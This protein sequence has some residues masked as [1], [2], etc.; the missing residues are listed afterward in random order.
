MSAAAASAGTR[1]PDSAG[2]GAGRS[3]MAAYGPTL[4]L[5]ATLAVAGFIALMSVVLLVVHPAS[6]PGVLGPQVIL[7]R[8]TAKTG[9]YVAS[10][11]VVLPLALFAG[12]RLADRVV[13]GDNASALA[14]L[15][16]ALAGALAVAIIAVKLSASL[17]W[18]DGLGAML[19]AVAVW[20]ALAGAL[21]AGAARMT[22]NAM[23]SR[24][25]RLGWP[26]FVVAGVLL[27]ATV[28]CLTSL[29]SLNGRG[30]VVCAAVGLGAFLLYDRI[31]VP[32]LG[33]WRGA[34][35]DVVVLVILILAIPDLVVFHPSPGPPNIYGEPG[36]IQFQQDWLLG[37]ANQLLAGGA[38]LVGDPVSQY[39][40]GSIYFMAGWF[41]LVP[42]GYGTFG[43]LDGILTALFYAAAYGVLRIA[44]L[45]RVLAAAA[46]TLGVLALI[47]NLHYAVGALPEQGPLRFGLPML[48]ILALTAAERWPERARLARSLALAVLGV[49]SIWAL[50]GFAYTA[51]TFLA[52]VVLAAVLGRPGERRRW[53]A[54]Q[55]ALGA[56]ACLCAHAILAVATL[57]V[58]GHLPDWGQY[59]AYLNGLLL[60]GKEGSITFG[61]ERWSPGLAVGAAWLTS[62][63]AVVLLVR[64][65]P[66]IAA[67]ERTTLIALGG[68]TAYALAMFSYTD[69]RSSTYLLLYVS[70]PALLI[71]ALWL[72]LLLRLRPA[73]GTSRG[74]VAFALSVAVLMVA[75]AWPSIGGHFS[76]SA[77]AHTYPA[78][79]LRA[80]LHQ[81]W[82]P[83]PLDPRAPEGERLLN[84]YA[85]GR[86]VVILL[87]IKVDLSIEIL[88]RSGKANR[89][90]LADANQDTFVPSVWKGKVSRGIAQLRRGQRLLIDRTALT[91]AATLHAH[92]RIDPLQHPIGAGNPE[93]EWILGRIDRRFRLRPI[94]RGSAGFVVAKLV[95]R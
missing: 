45:T 44:G 7:Q 66:E 88:M 3:D 57:A 25:E 95:R 1:S 24:L 38:L 69:N 20:W 52:V 48:L 75:A 64:R 14:A 85:P 23:P 65:R 42:I 31:R 35:I 21:L 11:L 78:G 61:F 22:R 4:A 30:L 63:A 47:Y 12:P 91:I 10:F 71:G 54:V 19:V 84:R 56:A 36:V 74:A 51:F 89:L 83:P 8:Q 58:T 93:I 67:R 40:V 62:A 29:R 92:P 16:G 18:G 60:G 5:T 82:H 70:L 94:A 59:L 80:A 39:G 6:A 17:P 79:G 26:V 43:F 37:P 72:G 90:F 55:L 27:F 81:L 2:E 77:L 33:G 9:L 50:E 53:L 46:L 73:R 68:M 28:L 13:A 34:G 86:R 49:S 32:R 41:H 76:D 87:P 15:V